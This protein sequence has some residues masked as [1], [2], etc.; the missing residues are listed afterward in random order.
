MQG[1]RKEATLGKP[2][3]PNSWEVAKVEWEA[4]AMRKH[5]E[6]EA[7]AARAQGQQARKRRRTA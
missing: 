1:M 5:D 4:R 6:T 7:K 2:T 3:V